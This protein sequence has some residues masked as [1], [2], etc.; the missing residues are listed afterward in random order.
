MMPLS[1]LSYLL[2]T[3]LALPGAVAHP[4][5][6][7][8]EELQTRDVWLRTNPRSIG[9][10][11]S[12]LQRRGHLDSAIARRG[13]LL[14]SAR[15][16]AGIPEQQLHRRDFANYDFSHQS[17]FIG[18]D[19]K[20]VFADGS[21]CI[22]TPEVNGL[23]H[24]VAGELMRANISEGQPGVPLILDVQ[25]INVRTCQ[26][27]SGTQVEVY[28]ANST[29]IYSGVVASGNGDSNDQS[30][31]HTTFGRGIQKTDADG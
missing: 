19:P 29:G 15:V 8:A 17:D 30:N 24:Y 16:N 5:H 12:Q 10:C 11:A 6:S 2:S 7:L 13:E 26:P 1:L 20:A 27:L 31:L 18:S 22:L 21:S 3:L 9:D 25:I 4:G 28:Q 14:R 23:G